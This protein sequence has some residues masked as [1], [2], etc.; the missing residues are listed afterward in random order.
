MKTE[1]EKFWSSNWGNKYSDRN[2]KSNY[3]LFFKK[4]LSKTKKVMPCQPA[5]A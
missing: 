1:Q 2:S 3:K 5:N 4:V